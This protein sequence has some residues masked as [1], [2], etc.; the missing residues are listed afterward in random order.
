[1]PAL[2]G[3]FLC[4]L[5]G[6]LH[7]VW[8]GQTRTSHCHPAARPQPPQCQP[9]C[10]GRML[11]TRSACSRQGPGEL[12]QG[13]AL[14]HSHPET[15]SLPQEPPGSTPATHEPRHMLCCGSS[16]Q[17]RVK[18]ASVCPEKPL[19]VG[20][21]HA[22]GSRTAVPSPPAPPA[23]AGVGRLSLS[24]QWM[25][26]LFPAGAPVQRGCWAM[27]SWAHQPLPRLREDVNDAFPLRSH[28]GPVLGQ[29]HHGPSV[30]QAI[31]I[32]VAD[33]GQSRGQ[34]CSWGS[35]AGDTCPAMP[36][37]ALGPP[38]RCSAPPGLG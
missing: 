5:P 36:G 17:A 13:P 6:W 34:R 3:P 9:W 38:S 12:G 22:G 10:Q 11:V 31:A 4:L 18:G 35:P 14:T 21:S 2:N 28:R 25:K 16:G 30:Q 15:L 7:P 1:M 33:C 24:A 27:P 26:V 20:T 8:H 23:P 32:G 19:C 37:I 29:A